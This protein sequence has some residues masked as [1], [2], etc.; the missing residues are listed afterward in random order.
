MTW[1]VFWL[2]LAGGIGSM[3][4]YLCPKWIYQLVPSPF[5]FGIF[6]NHITGC[7]LIGILWGLS[8]RTNIL[9]E[10]L[11]LFLLP[12]FVEASPLFLLSIMKG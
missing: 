11:N 8:I 1:N 10:E 6:I 3:A 7:L 2:D 9:G 12:D 5:P 4:R